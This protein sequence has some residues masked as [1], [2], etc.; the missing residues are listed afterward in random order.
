MPS[1]SSIEELKQLATKDPKLVKITKE[2]I[3]DI[4][5]GEKNENTNVN[6]TLADILKEIKEIRLENTTIIN[7]LREDVDKLKEQVKKQDLVIASHQRAWEEVD[8]RERRDKLVVLGVPE[9][10]DA[11]VAVEAIF[12]KLDRKELKYDLRRLGKERSDTD[13]G[14]PRPIL[15]VLDDYNKR[16]E[17]LELSKIL[18]T[19][20]N[21]DI[22][23]KVLELKT[24]YIKKDQ[25][26]AVRREWGRLHTVAKEE[27]AKPGNAGCVINLDPKRREILKDGVVIDK[28]KM[29]F[30]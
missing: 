3:I 27:K 13:Q 4:I 23:D 28:W 14:R 12:S 8:A 21:I 18:K 19:A 26:P 25:H 16:R 7:G 15:V 10:M 6:N 30:L 5:I 24:V 11:K 9:E 20:E 2:A 22:E 1:P 17:I 29:S